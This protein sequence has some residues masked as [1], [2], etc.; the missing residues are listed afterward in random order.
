M[1]DRILKKVS[2]A[3]G[4][5]TISRE[6]LIPSCLVI[7]LSSPNRINKEKPVFLSEKHCMSKHIGG[8]LIIPLHSIK[9]WKNID[10]KALG[11][12]VLVIV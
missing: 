6:R 11:A 7:M 8:I 12:P 2:A 9:N 1:S 4:E 3:H 5:R 10:D